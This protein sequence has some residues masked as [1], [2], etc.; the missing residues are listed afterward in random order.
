MYDVYKIRQQKY[1]NEQFEKAFQEKISEWQNDKF[2]QRTIL[3]SS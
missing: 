1:D 3:M 2:T